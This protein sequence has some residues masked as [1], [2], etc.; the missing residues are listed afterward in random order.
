MTINV[1]GKD[2]VKGCFKQQTKEIIINYSYSDEETINVGGKVTT[3][4][5]SKK[6]KKHEYI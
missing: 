2:L 4:R 3:K 5:S 6:K 1:G